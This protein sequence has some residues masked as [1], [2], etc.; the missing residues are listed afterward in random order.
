M[1][2]GGVR[3]AG[4]RPGW[5]LAAMLLAPLAAQAATATKAQEDALRR[6]L[7][8]YE[9]AIETK[10]LPL[11]R[12]VKPNLSAEEEKR[13]RKAFDST[14]THEV[15]ITVEA[16]DCQESRCMVRLARRDTLDGSIVSSFPQTLRLGQGPEGLVIEEIGR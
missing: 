4:G 9:R 5:L 7:A 1:R 15:T 3:G 6:L 2:C 11:F 14:R 13:L 8:S 12:S 10:D 16:L